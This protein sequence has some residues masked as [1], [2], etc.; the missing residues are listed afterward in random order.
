MKA[1]DTRIGRE[2]AS[3]WASERF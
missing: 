2:G 1:S 3:S